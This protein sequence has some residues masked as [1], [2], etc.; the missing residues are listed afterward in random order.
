LDPEPLRHLL[1]TVGYRFDAVVEGAPETYPDFDAGQGVRSPRELV[2]HCVHV[3]RIA[4]ASFEAEL[5]P[6]A[7]IDARWPELVSSLHHELGLL[8]GHIEQGTF[9]RSWTLLQMI[10]GPFADVLTHI[11]QL[12]LLRR[13]QG[14]PVG[15]QSYLR[16]QVEVGRTGTRPE[17]RG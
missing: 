7:P 6:S 12:A 15:R 17:P 5:E 9:P 2:G 8:D 14:D 13:L 11:G 1:A 3:L 16:A 10:Q 4:R